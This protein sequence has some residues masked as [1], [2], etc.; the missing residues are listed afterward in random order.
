MVRAVF[1][2]NKTI[3]KLENKRA[4]LLIRPKAIIH[5]FS[6]LALIPSPARSPFGHLAGGFERLH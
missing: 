4:K 5:F 6:A 1:K 3:K 2:I